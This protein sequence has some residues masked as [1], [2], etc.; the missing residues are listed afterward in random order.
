MQDG[1]FDSGLVLVFQAGQ[2]GHHGADAH[3]NLCTYRRNTESTFIF[4]QRT[5]WRNIS[6][7]LVYVFPVSP[8]SGLGSIL[9]WSQRQCQQEAP[10]AMPTK[11][12]PHPP[13]PAF[14]RQP[15]GRYVRSLLRPRLKTQSSSFI[16][17]SYFFKKYK[18]LKSF[19]FLHL[20]GTLPNLMV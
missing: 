6:A 18:N 19:F 20:V 4:L 10:V 9:L 7:A 15:V 3:H 12:W 5:F 13:P 11:L 16:S 14:S 8:A 1:V 17:A 2:S